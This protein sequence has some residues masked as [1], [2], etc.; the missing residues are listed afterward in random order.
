MED[1]VQAVHVLSVHI[2]DIASSLGLETIKLNILKHKWL[3]NNLATVQQA[4]FCDTSAICWKI[5]QKPDP[6][7]SIM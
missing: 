2:P 6:G 1:R 3:H 5:W 7:N 4:V